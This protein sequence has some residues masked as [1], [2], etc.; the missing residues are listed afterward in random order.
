MIIGTGVIGT[1]ETVDMIGMIGTSNVHDDEIV[2][3]SSGHYVILRVRGIFFWR[4]KGE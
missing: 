2:G 4:T 1:R 3:I